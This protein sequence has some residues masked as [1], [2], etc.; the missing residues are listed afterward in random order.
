MRLT[1]SIVMSVAFGTVAAVVTGQ[2]IQPAYELKSLPYGS[3]P[4]TST[5]DGALT[6]GEELRLVRAQADTINALTKRVE[7]LEQRVETLEAKTRSLR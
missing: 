6:P 4:R 3:T 5:S 2:T 7:S 1:S